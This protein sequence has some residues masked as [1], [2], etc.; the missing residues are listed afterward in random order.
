VGVADWRASAAN[1]EDSVL[2]NSGFEAGS[3]QV[4]DIWTSFG[5]NATR[6]GITARSGLYAGKAFGEFSG[7]PNFAGFMQNFSAKA[8]Q[9]WVASVWVRQN[10][11]DPLTGQCEAF[12]K[13][14]FYNKDGGF[15]DALEAADRISSTSPKDLFV[16][17]S[18]L[19]VAPPETATVR[20][21]AM[22]AQFDGKSKGSVFFDDGE[23]HQVIP[24]E[25]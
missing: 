23:L 19:S 22:F 25:K 17:S 20:F 11:D 2:A 4:A 14:E 1:M 3:N 6:D 12:A 7:Q 21:V 13:I 10:A 18:V 8:G 24:S 16:R 9:Q 5:K 15:I